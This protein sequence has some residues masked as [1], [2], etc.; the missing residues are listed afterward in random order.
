MRGQRPLTAGCTP[1]FFGQ[2]LSAFHDKTPGFSLYLP[3]GCHHGSAPPTP[4]I[5]LSVP[6]CPPAY[7]V[8]QGGTSDRLTG[9]SVVP[10]QSR[11]PSQKNSPRRSLGWDTQ[12]EPSQAEQTRGPPEALAATPGT[13]PESPCRKAPER[14]ADKC[15]M[16]QPV[17]LTVAHNRTGRAWGREHVMV[18]V[19]PQPWHQTEPGDILEQGLPGES[20]PLWLPVRMLSDRSPDSRRSLETLQAQGRESVTR[21]N[22]APSLSSC[23]RL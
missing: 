21:D 6:Q 20:K 4:S 17:A 3:T 5:L 9:P 19:G 13:S 2:Q 16:H 15:L 10:L 1:V 8:S 11:P 22:V 18:L 12:G 7:T 23:K 14:L